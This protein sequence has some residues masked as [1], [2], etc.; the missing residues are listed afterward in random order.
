M[1]SVFEYR[2]QIVTSR[3]TAFAEKREEKRE[4][5]GGRG[6]RFLRHKA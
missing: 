2:N 1:Q 5:G 6:S 4:N 3:S